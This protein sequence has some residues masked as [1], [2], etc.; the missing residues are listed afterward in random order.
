MF[1]NFGLTH[2]SVA[3]LKSL[4]AQGQHKLENM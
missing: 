3:T 2:C 4:L 1:I